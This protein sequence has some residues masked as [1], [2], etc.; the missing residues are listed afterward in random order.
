[1]KKEEDETL[2]ENMTSFEEF[3]DPKKTKKIKEMDAPE[4]GQDESEE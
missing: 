4:D 1:M 2:E 3:K